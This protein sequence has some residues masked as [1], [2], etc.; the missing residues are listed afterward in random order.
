MAMMPAV[1]HSL[2]T[3]YIHSH[4]FTLR[5]RICGADEW[6]PDE[7]DACQFADAH[8]SKGRLT[9]KGEV[10]LRQEDEQEVPA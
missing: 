2:S 7:R 1:E 10:Q 3:T 4:I 9:V 6:Y 8:L 5:T